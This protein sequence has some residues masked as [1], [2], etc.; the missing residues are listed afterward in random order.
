MKRLFYAP[1][2]S[3]CLLCV[4]FALVQTRQARA[5]D[6]PAAAPA[7]EQEGA[8]KDGESAADDRSYKLLQLFVD[9]M[10]QIDRNY[11]EEVD[12]RELV[13]AAIR[14]MMSRL[15]PHSNYIPPNQLER[16]RSGVE[17][18]FGGIGI[19]VS[20]ED[21]RLSVLSPLIGSPAYRQGLLAGDQITRIDGKSTKGITLVEAVRRLKGPVGTSVEIT[22]VR[23][24]S[25]EPVA[26]T[27]KR[28]IIKLETVLGDLRDADDKWIYM[29]DDE[30]KIGYL[31]ITSFGRET[32]RELRSALKSLQR[33]SMR[34]LVVDLRFN[35]GGLLSSAIR[36]CDMF[37][38]EGPIVSTDGR[39]A[40]PRKWDAQRVGTFE[41]FPMV[42]L[43][44]QFSASAS[45]IVAA[46]LQDHERSIVLG[47]RTWG[48]GSVQTIVELE[49]GKSA[50]KLTTAGYLRPNG[51]NIHRRPNAQESEEWG[52]LPNEEFEVK[53]SDEETRNIL[54]QRRQRDILKKRDPSE[55][56]Q[57]EDPQLGKALEHLRS[58]LGKPASDSPAAAAQTTDTSTLTP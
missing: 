53:L 51:K 20:L 13:E 12:R 4:V 7:A 8:V 50:M 3:V 23:P 35:P 15:D 49:N 46:C 17:S 32:A 34:G 57:A 54:R 14:G 16:F 52:V 19:Q 43:V 55:E 37:V 58:K 28:E 26:L 18:K 30:F 21:G 44:N 31:R 29:Y 45:E 48:K 41:G 33:Q 40:A 27:L 2:A 1:A 9:V 6:Q 24:D 5:D 22:I 39:N 10:D 25:E 56:A 38:T 42:I 11:V 47:Q 36:V